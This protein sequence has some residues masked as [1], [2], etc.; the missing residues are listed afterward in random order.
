MS[1][2]IPPPNWDPSYFRPQNSEEEKKEVPLNA[3]PS[4]YGN[5][6]TGS[7]SNPPSFLPSDH[8]SSYPY[9]IYPSYNQQSCYPISQQSYYSPQHDLPS[10]ST[11][12]P[13]SYSPSSQETAQNVPDLENSKDQTNNFHEL[14]KIAN[15]PDGV[16]QL[17][18]NLKDYDILMAG[19]MNEDQNPEYMKCHLDFLNNLGLNVKKL[20]VDPHASLET[21]AKT[22]YNQVMNQQSNNRKSILVGH[23]KGGSDVLGALS[24]YPHIQDFLEGVICLQ[25]PFRGSSIAKELASWPVRQLFGPVLAKLKLDHKSLESFT[26]SDRETFFK[27][28]NLN[29]VYVPLI[30]LITTNSSSFSPLKPLSDYFKKHLGADN[31]GL[32]STK[33]AFIPN[34]YT[35][36]IDGIDH[37]GTMIENSEDSK[38]IKNFIK[39]TIL[40][41]VLLVI[42]VVLAK[43]Y[44]NRHRAQ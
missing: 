21:N 37:N 13:Y 4:Y 25:T 43:K 8:S 12:Y 29:H 32:L 15:L 6:N 28:H 30:N 1:N 22:I 10:Y 16:N 23:S 33:D 35:I 38:T 34:A 17:A 24:L 36:N 11:Q 14:Y 19:G 40:L 20:L 2:P 7:S 5:V 44:R 39:P 18:S 27:D 31:D 41:L 9:P 3:P 26:S 42:V